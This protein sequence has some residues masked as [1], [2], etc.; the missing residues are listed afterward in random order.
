MSEGLVNV[1]AIV[2]SKAILYKAVVHE[3]L[4]QRIMS[5]VI[6]DSKMKV[7]EVFHH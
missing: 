3:L 1:E 5:W 6:M 4:M 7:L 2:Q